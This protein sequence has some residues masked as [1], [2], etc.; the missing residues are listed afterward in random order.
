MSF[1]IASCQSKRIFIKRAK[2]MACSLF[3]KKLLGKAFRIF[4]DAFAP[5]ARN[6]C[7]IGQRAG[8]ERKGERKDPEWE[9]FTY[10]TL[11]SPGRR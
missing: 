5:R 1:T 6:W 8:M 10:A 7:E 4:E 3:L 2:Q 11:E 9:G